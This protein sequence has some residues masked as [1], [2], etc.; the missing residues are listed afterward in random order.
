MSQKN[1][2]IT[3]QS[4]FNRRLNFDAGDL[5]ANRQGF[6]TFRQRR[7]LQRMRIFHQVVAWALFFIAFMGGFA[8][9]LLDIILKFPERMGEFPFLFLFLVVMILFCLAMIGLIVY[10]FYQHVMRITRDLRSGD[11][12]D[13]TGVVRLHTYR[14]SKNVTHYLYVGNMQFVVSSGVQAAFYEGAIYT[15]YYAP[16]SKIILSR[17]RIASD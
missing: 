1:K 4:I 9:M 2:G 11:A 12:D 14:T 6:I 7:R 10:L 15:V 13:I 16:E 8:V 3:R 5:Q 17:E